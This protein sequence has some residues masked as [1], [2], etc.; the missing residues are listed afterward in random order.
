MVIIADCEFAIRKA[1]TMTN[2][3]T[4]EILRNGM[5]IPWSKQPPVSLEVGD[6]MMMLPT[7]IMEALRQRMFAL[8]ECTLPGQRPQ[9]LLNAEDD[10]FNGLPPIAIYEVLLAAW[11]ENFAD[12]VD[13]LGALTELLSQD[14]MAKAAELKAFDLGGTTYRISEFTAFEGWK[15]LEEIRW[16]IG[17]AK[18][19]WS[20]AMTSNP[21]H[22]MTVPETLLYIP[23]AALSVVRNRLFQMVGFQRDDGENGV[24]A[25]NEAT[26]F[27]NVGPGAVYRVL[28]AA[29]AVNFSSSYPEIQRLISSVERTTNPLLHAI[30]THTFLS[31]LTPDLR[32]TLTAA[33]ASR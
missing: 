12:L 28:A 6:M 23:M 10:C 33:I 17:E 5:A 26:A 16:A 29:A 19:G 31:S 13:D 15:A 3:Q 22:P 9:P 8:V 30:F 2:F 27:A 1:D 11:Q 24:V 20:D 21:S 4:L 18:A 25:G 14:G 7:E 32:A